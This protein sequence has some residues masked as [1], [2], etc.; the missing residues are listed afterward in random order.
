MKAIFYVLAILVAGGA[1]YFTTVQTGKI[2]VVQKE[3]LDTIRT[4]ESVAANASKLEEDIVRLEGELGDA[5]EA[6]AL[7]SA[8][9]SSR[10]QN[11]STLKKEIADFDA[12]LEQQQQQFSAL[13]EALE[14][15]NKIL[16]DI[17][18]DVTLETLPEEVA[19]IENNK[20]QLETELSELEAL[21]EGGRKQTAASQAEAA[22]LAERK[23]RRNA[24]IRG[25]AMEAVVTAVNPEWGFIVI[26][27]GSN[28]GF[29][30]QT[31]LLVQRGGTL[32]AR[33][34]PSSIEP[35]QTIAEIDEKSLGLGVRV[36]PGDRVILAQPAT[37]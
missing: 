3:R 27:A 8:S 32:I 5:K 14:E 12:E 9:V 37:D 20:D 7:V 31:A 23:D 11:V 35:T 28:S 22:R 36:Q 10:T 29:T 15:V 30:P 21:I 25:N 17:G 4:N 26:G 1:A 19:N 6:E 18:T 13:E 33:V 16:K 34:K 24:R 2:E